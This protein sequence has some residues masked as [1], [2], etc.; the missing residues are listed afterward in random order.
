MRSIKN[1]KY[2]VASGRS[3][4]TKTVS[5]VTGIH[6]E[7]VPVGERR[8][9]TKTAQISARNEVLNS[10][11]TINSKNRT[12]LK[13]QPFTPVLEMGRNERENKNKNDCI[14]A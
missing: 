7:S 8:N 3:T 1:G 6:L 12:Q 5:G 4:L 14:L 2:F 10:T 9:H 11:E 13:L